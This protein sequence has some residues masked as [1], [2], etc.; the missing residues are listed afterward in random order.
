MN[1]H[2][3]CATLRVYGIKSLWKLVAEETTTLTLKELSRIVC[4][5]KAAEQSYDLPGIFQRGWLITSSNYFSGK[6]LGLSFDK[7]RDTMPH[8]IW[9]HDWMNNCFLATGSKH[10]FKAICSMSGFKIS[11]SQFLVK[12]PNTY[13]ALLGLKNSSHVTDH[14]CFWGKK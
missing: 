11:T 14:C 10:L 2:I 8:C 1:W 5:A 4:K 3:K 7:R 12:I 6:R 9:M 13:Q